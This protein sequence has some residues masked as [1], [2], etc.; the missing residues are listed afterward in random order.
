MGGGQQ[1]LAHEIVADATASR[2]ALVIHGVFG[3]SKN[4]R[5]FARRLSQS[6]PQWGFVLVDLPGHGGSRLGTQPNDLKGISQSLSDLTRSVN[7]PV[8]GIIGHSLGGKVAL[9]HALQSW[10]RWEQVWVLDSRLGAES[11]QERAGSPAMKVL[12][13]LRAVAADPIVSRAGFIEN[14]ESR[15]VSRSIA[16][17]LAMNVRAS[18]EGMRL[19]L[20]LDL[21]EK[22]LDSYFGTDLWPELNRVHEAAQAHIVVAGASGI[23][24]ASDLRRLEDLAPRGVH[25][26]VFPDAGHWV[27]VDAAAALNAVFVDA[28]GG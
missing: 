10:E 21:I 6:C 27:H 13:W 2:W 28:L 14:L 16:Q 24:D 19:G 25:Q 7:R 26:H 17:W 18:D 11:M 1:L 3:S 5:G 23:F 20:D 22:I 9:Y 12:G 15:G 4:W 8:S